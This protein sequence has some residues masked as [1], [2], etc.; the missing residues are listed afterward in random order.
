MVAGRVEGLAQGVYHYEPG[1][2]HL[3]K[4]GDDD[5]WEAL[6]RAALSQPCVNDAPAVI[7]FTADSARTTKKYGKRGRRYVVWKW[8]ML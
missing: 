6:A 1:R 8:A 4:T 7:V 3:V 5:V 2:H